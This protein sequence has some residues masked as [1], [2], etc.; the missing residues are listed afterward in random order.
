MSTKAVDRLTLG[1]L[2]GLFNIKGLYTLGFSFIFGMSIWVAFIGGVITRNVLTREQF[3]P[4]QKRIFS[5]YFTLS[6]LI[7]T[8]LLLAW[9]RNHD[10]VITHIT[11][12]TVPEVSQT[13]ALVVVAVSHALN[14]VWLGPATSKLSAAR[15]KLEKEE[16]RDARD[17][18]ES[19]E[20]R[21]LKAEFARMHGY[22]VLVNLASFFA[23]VFHGLWIGNYGAT[24]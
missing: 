7:S 23:L 4:L 16:G 19:T 6:T 20:M 18:N 10:N 15:V 11:Q 14:T 3:T 13:Y 2:F 1:T 9:I 5:M 8:G 17:A 21:A 22:S 12:P 24:A